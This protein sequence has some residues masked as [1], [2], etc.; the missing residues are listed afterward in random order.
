MISVSIVS[1]GH[2]R[3]VRSLFA[4][5]AGL[6]RSDLEVLL[7]LNTKQD[8]VLQRVRAALPLTILAN[9]TPR[10]YAANHNAAFRAARGEFFCVVNPD[11]RLPDDPFDRLLE[12]LQD[13]RIALAAPF[14]LE[15]DGRPQPTY[16][17]V[18]T[19][20]R[21]FMK[22]LGFKD[23]VPNPPEQDVFPDWVGGMFMLFRR[24]PFAAVRGFDERYYLY[25][26]DVDI[27]CRL[28]LAGYKICVSRDAVVVHE[29]QRASRRSLR[30]L[31]WHLQSI[32]KFFRSP[33][34]RRFVSRPR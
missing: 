16:R 14:V 5:I 10:G 19:P 4:D 24:E 12:P 31:R 27:C 23:A 8:R 18:P 20:G 15:S 11:V 25:Y 1:H 13:A 29:G 32:W 9:E 21:L 33:V 2:D 26:E 30:Y 3:H 7:T 17:P 6:G 34:Y 28:W 22:A